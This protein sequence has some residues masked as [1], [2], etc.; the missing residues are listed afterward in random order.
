MALVQRSPK[1][2]TSGDSGPLV[3]HDPRSITYDH[4]GQLVTVD[5]RDITVSSVAPVLTHTGEL[6][7]YRVGQGRLVMVILIRNPRH[8]FSQPRVIEVTVP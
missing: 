8:K 4:L 2:S 5:G 7:A 1:S 6:H 3:L